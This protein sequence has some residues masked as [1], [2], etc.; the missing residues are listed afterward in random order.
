MRRASDTPEPLLAFCYQAPEFDETAY[1][2]DTVRQTAVELVDL[3]TFPKTLW[4]D[5][6]SMLWHQD[7]PVH[8]MTAV[9]GYQL[10]RLAASKG[11]KVVLNGQGADETIGGYPNFFR[12]YWHTLL[13][14][15]RI[16]ETWKQIGD[17]SG[18]HNGNRVRLFSRQ[19]RHLMQAELGSVKLYRKLAH[20]AETRRLRAASPWFDQNFIQLIDGD[21]SERHDDLRSLLR[22]AVETAPL[23]LYLRVEDRN[24]MAHSVEVRL[25]FLDHRLVSLAFAL[26]PE[27]HLRGPWNKFVLREAMRGRIPESVRTRSDKMGFPNPSRRWFANELREPVLDILTSRSTRER[28]IY[29]VRTILRDAQLHG[30]DAIDLSEPLF[31]VAQFELWCSGDK[32]R[33]LPT[34]M[35]ES[36]MVA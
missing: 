18:A 28:G 15:G 17:H 34:D 20:W 14:A 11:V 5:L 33:N 8:S 1:I 36:V 4:D 25:P 2:A 21:E 9:I 24:S 19:L 3:A 32:V 29:N 13:R 6:G 10:M 22:R 26:T 12:D 35:R 30:R 23:P 7:E 16:V 31:R 27:W